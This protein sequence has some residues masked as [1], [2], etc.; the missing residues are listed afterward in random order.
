MKDEK[1][2]HH[3]LKML[4]SKY[5]YFVLSYNTHRLTMGSAFQKPTFYAFVEML[6][7][8][9]SHLIDLGLLMTSNTKAFVASDE[10]QSSQGGKSSSNNNKKQWKKKL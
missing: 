4:P 9:Q 6:I 10:N 5:A 8:K 7:V 2:I 1:L 3:I